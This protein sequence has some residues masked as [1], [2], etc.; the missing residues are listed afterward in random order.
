[1]QHYT[2]IIF[3]GT[4][5]LTRRKLIPAVRELVRK[6]PEMAVSVL[7]IGRTPLSGNDYKTLLLQGEDLPPRMTIH[8]YTGN[9]MEPDSMAGLR[10]KIESVESGMPAGRIFYLATSYKL[11]GRI[12][13]CIRS[14]CTENDKFFT[15]IIAEKPFGS[16]RKSFN[17]LNEE[18]KTH[19]T[20]SQIY[21][22][23]HY[24]AKGTVDNILR[25]RFSNPLF[26]SVWNSGFISRITIAVEEKLGVANRTGYYD[27]TGAIKD[28]VQNHLL[29]TLSLILM[30]TTRPLEESSFRQAKI[31]AID[32]LYFDHEIRTGQYRGYLDEVQNINPGSETETF[33]EL[34][35]LSRDPRWKGTGI[36]LRTGKKL[37]K[38]QAYIEIEFRGT[39]CSVCPEPGHVSNK[40]ILHIQ[41][42][43]NVELTI[44]TTLPGEKAELKPVKMTFC[45]TCEFRSNTPEA[46]EMILKECLRGNKRLFMNAEELD[47]AWRLTD[48]ILE[49]LKERK[50]VIYEPGSTGPADGNAG[51]QDQ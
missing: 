16:D 42:L 2:L 30:N 32:N 22:A 25:T 27:Q 15:R 45:P 50:P 18:L 26:E 6:D 7:G 20:E 17:R 31:N 47:I 33:A 4:G 5:D 37:K 51:G 12:A 28:M 13:K 19:F 23:D 36:V 40:L 44:N 3:G 14:C 29:Q 49:D 35:L 39:S 21:R 1:M 9:V 24:L 41:P 34:K 11:F 38:R 8:Y 48:S 43:Q 46:Y 10:E